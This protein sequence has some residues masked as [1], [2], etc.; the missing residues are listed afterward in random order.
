VRSELTEVARIAADRLDTAVRVDTALYA[1]RAVN[2]A[3]RVDMALYPL[4]EARRRLG[5]VRSSDGLG[6]ELLA[7][8]TVAENEIVAL[9]RVQALLGSCPR[10]GPLPTAF[11]SVGLDVL[12]GRRMLPVELR[13]PVVVLM[14]R[15][16]PRLFARAAE[17]E[18]DFTERPR[19]VEDVV[20]AV[21]GDGAAEWFDKRWSRMS[22]RARLAFAVLVAATDGADWLVELP[23][24]RHSWRGL[25]DP[26]RLHTEPDLGGLRAAMSGLLGFRPAAGRA[27]RGANPR[28]QFL[29][30]WLDLGQALGRRH[31]ILAKLGRSGDADRLLTTLIRALPVRGPPQ[32]VELL[33]RATRHVRRHTVNATGRLFDVRLSGTELDLTPGS[34][35]WNALIEYEW[36]Y[37]AQR[38]LAAYLQELAGTGDARSATSAFRREWSGWLLRRARGKQIRFAED[39]APAD[40]AMV[41]RSASETVPVLVGANTDPVAKVNLGYPNRHCLDCRTGQLKHL[42]ETVV[43]HPQIVLL[44]SWERR[45]DGSRGDE[46]AQLIV[47]VSEQGILPLGH[48]HGGEHLDVGQLFGAYLVEWAMATRLPLLKVVD[49]N[50]Y[51]DPARL[52]IPGFDAI[53]PEWL[54]I[55]LPAAADLRQE[56]WFD[57]AG[58]SDHLP[59]ID[60]M[61]VQRWT[62]PPVRATHRSPTAQPPR[63]TGAP[64]REVHVDDR[65]P[66]VRRGTRADA[67]AGRRPGGDPPAEVPAPARRA[68]VGAPGHRDDRGREHRVDGAGRAGGDHRR[69]GLARLRGRGRGLRWHVPVRAAGRPPGCCTRGRGRPPVDPFPVRGFRGRPR[70]VRLD[71]MDRHGARDGG[72]DLAGA[73][74]PAPGDPHGRAGGGL[75]GGARRA[76]RQR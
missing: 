25:V 12:A 41:A 11:W 3:V 1:L 75:P 15:S 70:L 69:A 36:S 72:T 49:G 54:E 56:M 65:D 31:A 52:P 48:P 38:A 60:E 17:A 67:R 29:G 2:V 9:E 20:H 44:G 55:T 53:Q 73:R 10:E 57:I 64:R 37:P 59:Y 16:V 43:L 5:V 26:L 14:A 23:G 33:Q 66:T 13:A 42:A 27:Q 50:R 32:Q 58:F 74:P 28:G 51:Y 34:P 21:L 46:L 40:A 35:L 39:Q 22:R 8:L 24:S 18:W 71:G 7:R 63:P 30:A 62:P 76:D 47:M 19:V 45:P 6:A 68:V 61:R 4:R